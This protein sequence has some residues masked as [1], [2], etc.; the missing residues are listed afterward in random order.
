MPE[1]IILKNSYNAKKKISKAER[2]RNKCFSVEVSITINN[3]H[4]LTV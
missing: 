4:V 2:C 1:Y 3:Y